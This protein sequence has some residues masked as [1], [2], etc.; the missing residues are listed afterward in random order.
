M[1]FAE[2]VEDDDLIDAVDELGPEIRLH[3]AHH[4]QL[5]QL[6]IVAGHLLDHLAAEVGGHHDDGVLEVHRPP[7]PVRHAPVVEHLQQDVEHVRVRLL[8][9]VEQNHAVRLATHGLGQVT[10]LVVTDVAGRRA[11]ETRDRV[12]LH[13]LAHIDADQVFLRIEEEGG[14][15]LAQLGLADAGRAEEEEGAV[16]AIGIGQAGARAANGIGDEAHRLVLADD[17]LVQAVFHAQQ[18]VALAF[19]HL[20]HRNAGGAR[21][22]LGDLLDADLVAQERVLHRAAARLLGAFELR[23]ELRQ[24]AVLQFGHLIELAGALQPRDFGLHAVDLFLD[25]RAAVGTRLLGLPHFF[26]I[27]VLA[28]QAGELVLDEL[29]ALQ[30]RLVLLLLHR[31]ALDLELDHAP[32]ELVHHL[33]LGIDLHLDPRRRL[34]DQVDRLVG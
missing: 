16:G 22:D 25:R 26:K 34:V 1:L 10:A 21:D 30:G 2:R 4:R 17:A 6:V 29:Q 18:L 5:D 27:V 15:G 14:Q 33:G 20:G 19:H 11:D 13:E 23:F 31:L 32:V 7:L 3:L 12:L 8:D 24:L 9:L 28:L